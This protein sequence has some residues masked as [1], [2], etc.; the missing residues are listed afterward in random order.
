MMPCM[1]RVGHSSNIFNSSFNTFFGTQN[2][3]AS[4]Q[5]ITKKLGTQYK[6]AFVFLYSKSNFQ[7][8][9]VQKP[10]ENG[11]Y[12]FFGLNNSTQFFIVAFDNNRQYNAVVQDNVVPK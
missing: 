3:V 8:V 11:V 10:S 12:E 1:R 7:P 6:D 4:I 5:G 9:A 2:T